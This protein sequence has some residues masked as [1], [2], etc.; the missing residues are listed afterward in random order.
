MLKQ[1]N[2]DL[3]DEDGVYVRYRLDGNLFNLSYAAFKLTPS[4]MRSLFETFSSQLMLP[5]LP[6][7]NEPC[8]VSLPASCFLL[9]ANAAQLFG[10]EVSLKKTEVLYQPAPREEYHPP[11][12][13]ISETELKSVQQFSYQGYTISSDARIDKE[14]DNRLAKASSAFD[15][16]YKR[17]WNNKNM[18]TQ[19]KISVYWTVVLTTLL[20]GSEAWVS[21]EAIL[22]K[23]KLQWAG[24]VSRMEDHRLPK[25][26]F[27]ANS[28]LAIVTE[29]HLR[30]ATK[31]ASR[32]LSMCDT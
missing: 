26:V 31:T 25:V 30:N 23:Y 6:K 28:P 15:R 22:L 4:L 20:Y 2:K 9:P 32:R 8:N 11:H 17:V 1:V 7:Q 3:V 18:K 27:M 13:T 10:L 21:I 29:G 5:W 14:V 19:T 16:L 12:I 24:H